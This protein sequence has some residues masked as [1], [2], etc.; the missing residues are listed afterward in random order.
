MKYLLAALLLVS[1]SAFA[2]TPE[3]EFILDTQEELNLPDEAIPVMQAE[4]QELQAGDP[5]LKGRTLFCAEAGA[6]AVI[7]VAGFTCRSFKGDKISM[8][9]I[10]IGASAS[11]HAGVGILHAKRGSRNFKEGT[12]DVTLVAGHF[13]LGLMGLAITNENMSINYRFKGITIGGGINVS[14]G[15]LVMEKI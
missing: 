15:K 8:S 5:Y 6:A 12:Y 10:G 11:L 13:G 14:V 1:S 2:L 3:D 7:D 9:L 4:L